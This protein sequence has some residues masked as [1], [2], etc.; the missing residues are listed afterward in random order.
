MTIVYLIKYGWRN[1]FGVILN[2]EMQVNYNK[3]LTVFKNYVINVNNRF[4]CEDYA[5][6]IIIWLGFTALSA[7]HSKAVVP[8]KLKRRQ[9]LQS[10]KSRFFSEILFLLVLIQLIDHIINY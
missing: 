8:M 6:I 5:V 9:N 4:I 7:L 2:S 10:A 3:Y 1:G